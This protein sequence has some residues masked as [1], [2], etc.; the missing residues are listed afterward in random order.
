MRILL[1][2]DGS[3][4]SRDAAAYLKDLPLPPA[5]TI[6][7]VSVVSLPVFAPDVSSA[8]Q[9]KSSFLD[10]ARAAVADARKALERRGVAVETDVALG[11]P[12]TE[13]VRQSE[14]WGADLVVL[15]ARGL[16]RVKRF[17]QGS[18]SD[19]VAHHARCAVLIVRGRR[20]KLGSV[21]VAMDGSEDSFQAVR[22][23]QSFVLPRQARVRLVSV[24]ERLRYPTTAPK[25]LRGQ[26]V[27]MIK[28]L[29]AERRGELDKVLERAAGQLED[30]ITRV[31]RSTPTGD[32]ADEIVATADDF[33][34]DLVVVGARGLGGVARALLGSVS[35]KVLHHARCPVLIVKQRPTA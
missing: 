18:V 25:A 1:A 21:V 19:A 6:R 33:D 12:R 34:A 27:A 13:I 8:P 28:E 10:W 23:L 29:E 11:E 20:R 2:V 31:T 4:D 30:K 9:L 17:L 15:G 26:L 24:V 35:E 3:K 5:T 32:P 16:G 22:F 14:E 7:V